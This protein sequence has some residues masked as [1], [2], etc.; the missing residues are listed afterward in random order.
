[1]MVTTSISMTPTTGETAWS[2]LEAFFFIMFTH[3]HILTEDRYSGRDINDLEIHGV[4][5]PQTFPSLAKDGLHPIHIDYPVYMSNW[6][7]CRH[8]R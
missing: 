4:T 1:M 7:S 2:L 6:Y 5:G 8:Y 3:H